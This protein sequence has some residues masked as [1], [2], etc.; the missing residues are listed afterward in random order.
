[1]MSVEGTDPAASVRGHG[2]FGLLRAMP[3]SLQID[4]M[5]DRGA[6]RILFHR[7]AVTPQTQKWRIYVILV[8][9][10][11]VAKSNPPQPHPCTFFGRARALLVR[12]FA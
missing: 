11:R 7:F 3:S 12:A 10:L 4:K 2:V 1:M 9:A 5:H 8:P 6:A